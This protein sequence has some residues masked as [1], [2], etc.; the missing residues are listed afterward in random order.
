[1]LAMR[2]WQQQSGTAIFTALLVVVV[3]SAVSVGLMVRMRI[4]L[5]RTEQING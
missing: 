2:Q 5:K 1:M 3:A 4:D